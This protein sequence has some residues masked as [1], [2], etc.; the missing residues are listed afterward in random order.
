MA[1]G[2]PLL[3]IYIFVRNIVPGPIILLMPNLHGCE[4]VTFHN[5]KLGPKAR[6]KEREGSLLL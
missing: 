5:M 3:D 6:S 4:K 2:L 1:L